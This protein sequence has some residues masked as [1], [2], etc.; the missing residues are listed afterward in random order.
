MLLALCHYLT[1]HD[2]AQYTKIDQIE[3]PKLST[4]K[5]PA[6]VDGKTLKEAVTK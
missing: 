4:R 2:I 1:N 5:A 6:F 3:N